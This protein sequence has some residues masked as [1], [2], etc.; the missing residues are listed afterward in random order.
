VKVIAISTALLIGLFL[1]LAAWSGRPSVRAERASL[2]MTFA[3]ADHH[4]AGCATCHHNFVDSVGFGGQCIECHQTDT[5]VAH[6]VEQQFHDLCRGCHVERRAA[7]ERA[8]PV[9]Q[10]RACHTEDQAP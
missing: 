9:R 1:A 8:G 5:S 2:P 3:H 6:L 7:G 4:A 10:C